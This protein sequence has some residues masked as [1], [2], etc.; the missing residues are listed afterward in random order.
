MCRWSLI[1]GRLQGRTANDIKN[2]WNTKVQKKLTTCNYQT[3]VFK[4]EEVTRVLI[5]PLPHT[6][7]TDTRF[8]CYNHRKS[9]SFGGSGETAHH[10]MSNNNNDIDMF[11]N[12]PATPTPT[13]DHD[14]WWKNLF[15]ELGNAGQEEDSLQEQLLGPLSGL[16]DLDAEIG[17]IS[18]K[19][20]FSPTVTEATGLLEDS[21]SPSGWSDIWDLLNSDEL[22][23]SCK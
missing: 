19:D 15:A 20:G 12:K 11:I 10:S 3:E 9:F 17:L 7:F 8:P 18:K 23:I 21:A 2:F 6:I 14:Q 22:I 5:K 13:P 4:V 1:A 16:E